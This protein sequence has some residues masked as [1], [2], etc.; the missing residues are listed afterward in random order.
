MSEPADTYT[1]HTCRTMKSILSDKERAL[2]VERGKLQ[3][4]LLEFMTYVLC[5]RILKFL[6][7]LGDYQKMFAY[8]RGS[9]KLDIS[10]KSSTAFR[11]NAKLVGSRDIFVKLLTSITIK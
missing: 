6:K 11:S 3:Q 9:G 10:S 2:D 4:Q 5:T 7:S 1:L 8:L